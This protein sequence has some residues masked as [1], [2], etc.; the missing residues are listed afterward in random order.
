MTDKSLDDLAALALM[1][2]FGGGYWYSSI[3]SKVARIPSDKLD[4]MGVCFNTRGYPILLYNPKFLEKLTNLEAVNVLIHEALHIFFRHIT[5]FAS[6]SNHERTNIA[7]DIAINQ[8]LKYLPTKKFRGVYP[9]DYSFPRDLTA[10]LYYDLLKKL[11]EKGGKNNKNKVKVKA[12][13]SNGN[14]QN[15]GGQGQGQQGSGN[16]SGSN[17]SNSDD[18]DQNQNENGGSGGS[19]SGFDDHSLWGKV[20]DEDGNLVDKDEAGVDCESNLDAMIRDIIQEW[21]QK[22]DCPAFAKAII[23]A[24]EKKSEFDWRRQLRMYVNTALSPRRRLSQKRVNRRFMDQEYILPGKKK[25][26]QASVLVVRDTSG[27]MWSTEVQKMLLTEVCEL[28]K[29]ADVWLVD[30]DTE[31]K[32]EPYKVKKFDDV[33]EFKGGGGTSFVAPFKTA[34][35]LNVDLVIYM[36]DLCGDFPD[37]REIGRYATNTIWCVWKENYYRDE[38]TPFGRVVVVDALKDNDI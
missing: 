9:E 19:G 11:E 36:T 2:Q 21:K 15:S 23:E 37:K 16:Q 3:I 33:Q 31:V 5:R 29:R 7:C 1:P 14:Q 35:K 17:N 20:L 10:E 4:T 18:D 27:S 26:R 22:G 34:K 28:S 32:C 25:C 8:N 38:E 12:G 6:Y 13:S 24:L 30:C